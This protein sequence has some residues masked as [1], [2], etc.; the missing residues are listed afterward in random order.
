MNK[1]LSIALLGCAVL[2]G[3]PGSDLRVVRDIRLENL[4]RD[5]SGKSIHFVDSNSSYGQGVLLDV[6]EK[7]IIISELG[8]PV[9]YDHSGIDHVFVD[10]EMKELAMVIGLGTL[11][12]LAGYLGIIRDTFPGWKMGWR[13]FFPDAKTIPKFTFLHTFL[14]TM[15]LYFHIF[16]EKYK[17]L[18]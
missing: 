2:A 14:C 1:I 5:H 16:H 11:G 15:S 3:R 17:S 6:T 12:G 9:S 10:P 13:I 7:N 4:K 8:S 18:Q